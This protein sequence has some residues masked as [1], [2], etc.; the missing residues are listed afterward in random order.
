M[1]SMLKPSVEYIFILGVG[2]TRPRW[3]LFPT[4]KHDKRY[5]ARTLDK[6]LL[7]VYQIF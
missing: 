4:P 2:P 3:G 6:Y 1:N 7:R 5:S